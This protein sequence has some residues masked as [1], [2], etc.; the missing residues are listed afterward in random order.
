MSPVSHR[1]DWNLAQI[2]CSVLLIKTEMILGFIASLKQKQVNGNC[3]T[4]VL[5]HIS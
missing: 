4:P 2:L 5:E 1:C 3:R